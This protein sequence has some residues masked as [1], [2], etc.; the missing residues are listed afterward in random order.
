MPGECSSHASNDAVSEL[1]APVGAGSTTGQGSHDTTI[2]L[3]ACCT[4]GHA[5]ARWHVRILTVFICVGRLLVVTALIRLGSKALIWRWCLA[6]ETACWR[7]LAVLIVAGVVVGLSFIIWIVHVWGILLVASLLLRRHLL[8]VRPLTGQGLIAR[9][10]FVV[11][12]FV[13]GHVSQGSTGSWPLIFNFYCV[14]K[15]FK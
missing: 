11:V 9:I 8:L 6:W 7:L 13:R 3:W 14:L 15:L 4:G 5:R 12:V 1:M 2:A 10:A